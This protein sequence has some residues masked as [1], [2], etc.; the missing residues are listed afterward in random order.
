MFFAGIGNAFT[1]LPVM[2]EIVSGVTEHYEKAGIPINEEELHNNLAGY[3]NA[4][5][6]IG[7]MVGPAT[8]S[9]V[10]DNFNQTWTK[11][12]LVIFGAIYISIHIML[13]GFK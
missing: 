3:F 12:F 8:C 6:S 13:C 11:S 5:L 4:F 7:E 10:F 9:I 1:L 2:P